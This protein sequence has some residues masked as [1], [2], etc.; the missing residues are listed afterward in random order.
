MA[1]ALGSLKLVKDIGR[2]EFFFGLA[3]VPHSQQLYL[4]S[5]DGRVYG[6]DLQAEKPEFREFA[7]HAGYVTSVVLAGE[8]LISG[9]YDGKLIWWD[10]ET[11][12]AI[13]TVQAHTRWI[14]RIAA[15][16]DGRWLISVADDMVARIRDSTTG[17]QKF[18]LRGHAAR[19]PHHFPSMLYA[20][21]VSAD[22]RLAA[23]VDK[24]GHAVVWNAENGQP[25]QQIEVPEMYTWDPKQRIHSIGGPRS[26][27]FSPDS[28]LLAIGGMGQ[29]G[30]ID[31]LE[32][33]ARVELFNWETGARTHAFASELK[34]LVERL[35]FH[36]EG[37]WL[38][39]A[40]GDHGGA[41]LFLDPS[42]GAILK[43]EKAP[44]HLHDLAFNENTDRIYAAAH[45][46]ILAWELLP[47]SG[48]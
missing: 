36:P 14:R 15:S 46:K 41:L 13:R 18:E 26:L 27:A 3:R 25:L 11:L 33:K 12:Q 20:C 43:E 17:E 29:V 45:G 39:A 28:K 38:A 32:G 19:T 8:Q 42:A 1:T 34:G 6:V 10:R 48:T 5:S 47:E 21:A 2:K 22:N 4:G 40:G 7:G 16:P 23:T 24:T 37:K 35:I 31:H 9:G 30:N 44:S